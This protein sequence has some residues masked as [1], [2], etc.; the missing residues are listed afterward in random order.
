MSGETSTPDN[1]APGS[2][3]VVRDEEWLVTQVS[4]TR[5]GLL[6]DVQGLSELVAGTSAQ[7]SQDLDRIEVF[8][9]SL[10]KVVADSSPG[11]RRARLWLEATL[12]KTPLPI[13]DPT[14]AVA[15]DMLLDPLD[16]Q[17]KAVHKALDPSILRPRILLAD[18]VGLGK[19]LEIGMILSELVRRG[20]GERILIVT[21]RHVLEQ[22]QQEMWTRFALPFVRLDSVG[23]QQVRR[24]LPATRN[25][26]SVYRRAIISIDTLKS[27]RYLAHLRKHRWDAVVIDESHN[28]TGSTTQNNRLANV[29]APQ[30]DALILAS[31]TPHNGRKESFAELMRL[32][33]PT[34]VDPD[35]EIDPADIERLVV[36]RHRNSAE[37]ASVVGADWAEREEPRNILVDASPDED[38]MA[39][40]LADHWLYG[41]PPRTGGEA[42]FG[43]TLG[44]AFLSSPAALAETARA[45][46]KRAEHMSLADHESLTRLA[47]LAEQSLDQRTGK[48]A[49]L[50]EEFDR[51]GISVGSPS[52]V[53][54]FAERVATLHWL[55]DRIMRD[56]RMTD[57]QVRVLHGGLS[58]VEQQE[59][60]DSFKQ[61]GSPIRVLVTG[62]VASEGVNL[63]RQCHELI[64]FDIPWSLIRI[65]QRNG[66]IDRYGQ[67]FPPL[68]TTLLL[69][70]R[71][72]RF[73]GDVR[74]LRSLMEK[75]YEAHRALGD[76]ASIM[77]KYDVAAEE[78]QILDVLRGRKQLEQ[79]IAEPDEVIDG[80]DLEAF[81]ARLG[82]GDD[83]QT[84]TARRTAA[85]GSGLYD[86]PVDYLREA[87]AEVYP[88]PDEAP[89][90]S[91]GGGIG[92]VEHR[93]EQIVELT[94]PA[95][96][97]SR[98]AVLP[99][100]YLRE[101][102]VTTRLKLATSVAKGQA[103]MAAA[104]QDEQESSWPAAHY[105][106]PLHPVLD[107][108]SDRA[109][110]R[111]GRGEVYAVRGS[112]DATSVLVL[113][114]LTNRAGQTVSSAWLQVEFPDPDSPLALVT[115][116]G[117]AAGMLD[118]VGVG[119]TMSNPGAVADVDALSGL[120]PAAMRRVEQ[121]LAQTF[122]A[123]ERQAAQHVEEW[124]TRATAWEREAEALIQRNDLRLRRIG[125]A[126]QES[127][128]Q[129]RRPDRTQLRPLLVVV[130]AGHAVARQE[131]E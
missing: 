119:A 112:G 49:A 104:L 54:V 16:Y 52:R 118:A 62:D 17:R 47:D 111:L 27:D 21:P 73:S 121:H 44:K 20:R 108:V 95:D 48:Y 12:R 116:H 41:G 96:L 13:D 50:L 31:A 1:I 98:L 125:V 129:Q 90:T 92:W 28:I 37:V 99:Q 68:I 70:P 86:A 127:L 80:D 77:G 61:E 117:S 93:A 91:G 69:Q 120:I 3:V 42:L 63:H 100:S 19:T 74:V 34:S 123:A 32:L 26:F 97:R 101:R 65:E 71:D 88:R 43:W 22:M 103:L 57:Q 107:W 124:V 109:L 56:R 30:T 60:V 7:F 6:V 89:L 122:T 85:T 38:A 59:I 78:K 53:V 35:G 46:M 45:R 15:D 105:L 114:T 24:R 130:P 29:L 79:V 25:P 75:E 36:R 76:T 58:D 83:E 51:I 40:E 110:A 55:R 5:D 106:G 82:Q 66:R 64:H 10:T 87:V 23:I 14:L 128:A 18:A 2:L 131:G 67:Q 113:G 8:D 39:Q 102:E 72:D 81:L 11:Y 115:P 9:P 126:D 94:P 33:E 4:Q 84:P